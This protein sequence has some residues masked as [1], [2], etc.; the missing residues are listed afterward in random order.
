MVARVPRAP[1]RAARP[2][3]HAR[4]G[5]GGTL[6]AMHPLPPFVP[7]A[8]VF[9]LDGLLVDSEGLWALAERDVVE[10][11]GGTW[12]PE[13]QR[14]MLGRGPLE[15]A[16]ILAGFAGTDDVAEVDRRLLAAAIERFR[17]GVPARPGA[18]GLVEAL[19]GR[20]PL[21][22]AT[23]SRRVLADLALDS[24]GLA[25][26][27]EAVVCFEDVTLPK[28]APDA[29]V[30]ACRLLRAAPAR[31]V[32]FEDSPAGVRSAREAGLWVVGCPS[33]PGTS[34]DAAHAVI[35]SLRDVDPAFLLEVA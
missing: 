21:G 27:F 7:A 23:N 4:W 22:V 28:P 13:A 24:A 25:G 32:A 2:V 15:A 16:G 17:T 30:A 6:E 31:T 26:A 9:D 10:A 11:Y 3:G 8:V 1:G 33:L 29:Y 14:L 20:L 34:L 19:R 18:S 12:T 35:D 5:E